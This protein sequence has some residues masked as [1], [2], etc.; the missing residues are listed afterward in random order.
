MCTYIIHTI[1]KKWS[2]HLCTAKREDKK[3]AKI[4]VVHRQRHWYTL[5]LLILSVLYVANGSAVKREY[6]KKIEPSIH[7]TGVF[8]F[9]RRAS[10]FCFCKFYSMDRVRAAAAAPHRTTLVMWMWSRTMYVCMRFLFTFK[11]Y[12]STVMT[13]PV[14]FLRSWLDL[15]YVQK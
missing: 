7:S 11:L 15:S 3:H 1:P 10:G 2:Q 9:T 4:N 14:F 8:L 6:R 12:S 5:A 13:L